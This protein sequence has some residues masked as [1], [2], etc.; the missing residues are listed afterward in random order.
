MKNSELG[1][2]YENNLPKLRAAGSIPVSRSDKEKAAM[3]AFLFSFP[4]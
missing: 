2:N 3:A 1:L 4:I